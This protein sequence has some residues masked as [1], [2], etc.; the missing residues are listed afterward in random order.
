MWVFGG[1]GLAFG[2]DIGGVI[3]NPADFFD[4]TCYKLPQHVSWCND[5][6]LMFFLYQLMFI[7]ITV[8]LMTGAFAGRLNLKGYIILVILESADLFPCLP[9]DMGWRILDQMGFRDFAGGAVI[10]DSWIRLFSMYP[11]TWSKKD[12][13][14]RKKSA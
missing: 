8:P 1:F 3:G 13:F 7:V 2:R 4:E 14:R 10:H 9:L 5:S 6:I 11:H 12:S